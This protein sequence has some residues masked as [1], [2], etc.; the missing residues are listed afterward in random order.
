MNTTHSFHNSTPLRCAI[1]TVSD[2]RTPDTDRGGPLVMD[3]LTAANHTIAR[4]DIL[5]DDLAAIRSHVEG[6]CMDGCDT[7]ILTGGTG[8]A[9]RDVTFEAIEPLLEKRLDGFGEL[10]RMLSFEQIG[11][12]ALLSRTLAGTRGNS[13]IFALPGSPKAVELAMDRLILPILPHAAALL[14]G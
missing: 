3:R 5:P 6:I 14:V 4:Y 12:A 11:P 9:T 13:L 8:I 7:I 2:T 1:V 10:F